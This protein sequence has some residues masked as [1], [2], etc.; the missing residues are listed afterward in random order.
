MLLNKSTEYA[1]KVLSLI[2]KNHSQKNLLTIEISNLLDIKPAYL[3]KILQ[4][5]Q[6]SGFLKS[7]PGPGGGF[8]MEPHM[9]KKKIIEVV[10]LFDNEKILTRCILGMSACGDENPCPFHNAWKIFSRELHHYL[11]STSIHD[12]TDNIWPEF[13]TVI[14]DKYD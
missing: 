7:I 3:S 1:L 6:H 9:Q 12:L 14:S 11:H 10:R 13:N 4:K 2:R 5:L 8:S